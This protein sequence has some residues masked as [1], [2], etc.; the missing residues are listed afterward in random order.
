MEGEGDDDN[1]G[2]GDYVPP[3]IV[4]LRSA[5]LRYPPPRS[6]SS[7]LSSSSSSSR[8]NYDN[9]RRRTRRRGARGEDDRGYDDARPRRPHLSDDRRRLSLGLGPFDLRVMSNVG[10]PS[11]GRWERGGHVALGK[12]GSGK[13]LLYLALASAASRGG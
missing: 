10:S 3:P 11:R 8:N 13:T 5:V 9:V 2:D 4:R 7:S 12:N 1:G 6:S